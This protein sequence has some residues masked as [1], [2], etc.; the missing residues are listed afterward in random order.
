MESRDYFRNRPN[1]TKGYWRQT[2]YAQGRDSVLERWM[3]PVAFL[4]FIAF[5]AF[6]YYYNTV[7]H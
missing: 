2:P 7:L 5:C 1:P 3:V 4:G 6:G